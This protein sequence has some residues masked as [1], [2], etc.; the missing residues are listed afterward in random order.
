M[1]RHQAAIRLAHILGIGVIEAEM[2]I[3]IA[4]AQSTGTHHWRTDR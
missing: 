1:T 2:L 4:E 3:H